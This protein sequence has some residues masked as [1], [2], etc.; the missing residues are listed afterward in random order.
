MLTYQ[1]NH[2]NEGDLANEYT[3]FEDKKLADE[4][5]KAT[6]KAIAH[7]DED[8]AGKIA[9]TEKLDTKT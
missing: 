6:E 7:H 1:A 9:V 8:T 3:V 4:A 5:V 2:V